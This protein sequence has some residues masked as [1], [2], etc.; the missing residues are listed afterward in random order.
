MSSLVSML[1]APSAAAA[2]DLGRALSHAAAGP[3]DR[4]LQRAIGEASRSG[5]TDEDQRGAADNDEAQWLRSK[6]VEKVQELASALGA[7][8][9]EVVTLRY[10]GAA[11]ELE[12][13]GDSQAAPLVEEAIASDPEMAADLAALAELEDGELALT[14]EVGGDLV[15]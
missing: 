4:L 5:S 2:V 10:D 15:P 6:L 7:S 9:G 12:I 3:F 13:G 8:E 11:G 14:I 1:V